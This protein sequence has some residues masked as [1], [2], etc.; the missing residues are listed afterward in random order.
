MINFH[1]TDRKAHQ[2]Y[3]RLAFEFTALVAIVG[4]F[5]HY[6]DINSILSIAIFILVLAGIM[7]L[8][9]TKRVLRFITELEKQRDLEKVQKKE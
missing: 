4:G 5:L 1:S 3:T 2:V 6:F 9:A 7:V 8:V